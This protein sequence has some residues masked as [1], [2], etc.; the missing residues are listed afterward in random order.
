M[1][2]VYLSHHMYQDGIFR[3]PGE[4]R[5]IDNNNKK[6]QV[7]HHSKKQKYLMCAKK[8]VAAAFILLSRL[9]AAKLWDKNSR[10]RVQGA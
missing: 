10:N 1:T 8:E 9:I 4:N 5:N 3:A 6:F 7:T 2:Q